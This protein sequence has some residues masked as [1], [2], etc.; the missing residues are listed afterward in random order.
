MISCKGRPTSDLL[1]D[2]PGLT[3]S[4]GDMFS[5][6][7]RRRRPRAI[8]D[9]RSAS[10]P[11]RGGGGKLTDTLNR[12]SAS[13]VVSLSCDPKCV[14][15][16]RSPPDLEDVR[17]S[18]DGESGR[19]QR[20]EAEGDKGA[21]IV[22]VGGGLPLCRL[23]G[24]WLRLQ[25]AYRYGG[26]CAGRRQSCTCWRAQ[27]FGPAG[28]EGFR[29]GP[30]ERLFR[31]AVSKAEPP[32]PTSTPATWQTTSRFPPVL[33]ASRGRSRGVCDGIGS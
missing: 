13:S 4:S 6:T 26:S 8:C 3:S 22:G 19:R 21:A 29:D 12:P 16:L 17:R 30:R 28:T 24:R 2:T 14:P 15:A 20:A 33:P 23:Q 27:C 25:P 18:G 5:P 11:P 10:R 7:A 32:W 9:N 31:G 1:L